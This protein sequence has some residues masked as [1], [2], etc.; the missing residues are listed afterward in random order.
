MPDRSVLCHNTV[1]LNLNLYAVAAIAW[2]VVYSYGPLQAIQLA[3][4]MILRDYLLV[5]IV[6]ATLLWYT[7]LKD[8]PRLSRST[9]LLGSS[10]TV[11]LSRHH[12]TRLRQIRLLNGHMHLMSTRT[13]SF[14]FT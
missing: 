3:L 13:L 11:Y 7:Q 2:S 9:Y 14:L 10:P 5:G 1:R 12:H 8:V 6:I 4:L